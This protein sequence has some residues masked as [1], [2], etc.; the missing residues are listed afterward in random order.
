MKKA[1]FWLCILF[2]IFNAAL[3]LGQP[4]PVRG[5]NVGNKAPGISMKNPSGEVMHLSD[6]KGHVVLVDFWASWC[7]PCRRENP[8]VVRAYHEFKNK[9]FKN[10]DGFRV[11]SVSLD[12]TKEAWMRAINEDKLD[13]DTQVSELQGWRSQIAKTYHVR[14]I[15]MNYLLDENGIIIDKNLRGEDLIKA[16]NTFVEH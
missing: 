10:G 11:F 6:L 7:R 4:Q 14:S 15:P 1:I 13:W 12:K 16:L 5:I 9:K 2:F 3:V 8:I